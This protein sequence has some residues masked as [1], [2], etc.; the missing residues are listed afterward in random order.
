MTPIMEL[1]PTRPQ[2]GRPLVAPVVLSCAAMG[3]CL[4]GKRLWNGKNATRHASDLISLSR[5][6]VSKR[7]PIDDISALWLVAGVMTFTLSSKKL[8][9]FVRGGF[10]CSLVAARLFYLKRLRQRIEIEQQEK[11]SI[12]AKYAKDL[13]LKQ[14][15]CVITTELI[16]IP[17]EDPTAKTILYSKPA[18]QRWLAK[19]PSSPMTRVPMSPVLLMLRREE[20][21]HALIEFRLN[22]LNQVSSLSEKDER[23]SQMLLTAEKL[24]KE[25]MYLISAKDT[26]TITEIPMF[27]KKTNG[28]H[29]CPISKKIIRFPMKPSLPAG[30]TDLR[31]HHVCYEAASIRLFITDHPDKVP[32]GWPVQYLPLPLSYEKHMEINHSRKSDIEDSL[33]KSIDSLRRFYTPF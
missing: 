10:I 29:L 26:D 33:Q 12:P 15:C 24:N 4:I 28:M 31:A 30:V 27:L 25:I 22:Q 2:I 6:R 32:P 20:T 3:I 17:L 19:N 16:R 23:T 13:I 1:V 11:E 14:F 5:S 7:N 9:L 21:I 8:P 18:L